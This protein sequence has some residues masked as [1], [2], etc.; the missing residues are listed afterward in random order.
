[1]LKPKKFCLF[2]DNYTLFPIQ[3]YDHSVNSGFP[4]VRILC[5]FGQQRGIKKSEPR[6]DNCIFDCKKELGS[7]RNDSIRRGKVLVIIT[8]FALVGTV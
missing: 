2:R 8:I 5:P 1:M 7:L 3:R 4:R 6:S